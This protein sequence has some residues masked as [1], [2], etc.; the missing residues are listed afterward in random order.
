MSL[1]PDGFVILPSFRLDRAAGVG[2]AIKAREA[3]AMFFSPDN[4]ERNC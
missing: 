3:A 2:I 4:G 1:G